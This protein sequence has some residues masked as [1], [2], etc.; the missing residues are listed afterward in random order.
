MVGKSSTM[1]KRAIIV[2]AVIAA[3][4]IAFTAY[5]AIGKFR[6]W[7]EMTLYLKDKVDV[8]SMVR[9]IETQHPWFSGH[10]TWVVEVS[11]Y[12]EPDVTYFYEY[13]D[14]EMKFTKVEGVPPNNESYRYLFDF[15]ESVKEM[16]TPLP[17]AY[18]YFANEKE[19]LILG[20]GDQA[21]GTYALQAYATND[22]GE[23]W[24][25]QTENEAGFIAVN[26]VSEYLFLSLDV[27]FIKS[28]AQGEDYSRLLMTGNGGKTFDELHIVDDALIS[29][30]NGLAALQK[31][32]VYDYYELPTFENGILKVVVS[33]GAD[34]DYNG[35]KTVLEYQSSDM[36][37]NW[38]FVR[39]YE[40]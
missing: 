38:E 36:G 37:A 21:M 34:G 31:D 33:Q 28:P 4:A 25:L 20:I 18:T 23:T 1:K 26:I 16:D 39:E 3:V 6:I 12:A 32:A 40:R 22:G 11:F 27:G 24:V 10:G 14:E 8:H 30:A 7:N 13:K 17:A 29:P 19:A 15:Q 35:G 5:I 2:C 9:G